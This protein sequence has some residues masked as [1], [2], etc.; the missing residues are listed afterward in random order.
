MRSLAIVQG[1]VYQNRMEFIHMRCEAE[2]TQGPFIPSFCAGQF[3]AVGITT[4]AY[5]TLPTCNVG[6]ARDSFH[7]GEK[8]RSQSGENGKAISLW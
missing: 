2:G 7:Q 4:P 1:Y 8:I 6:R 3:H 5:L